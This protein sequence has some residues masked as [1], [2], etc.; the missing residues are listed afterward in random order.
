MLLADEPT[1]ALDT[2][3]SR[4]IMVILQRLNRKDGVTIVLVTH[5]REIAAHASRVVTFRDGQVVGDERFPRDPL[6]LERSGREAA[7]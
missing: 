5:D 6:S 1:G 2:T 4:E 3:T 7:I